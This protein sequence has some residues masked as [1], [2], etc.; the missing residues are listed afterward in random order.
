[1]YKSP[2][3]RQNRSLFGRKATVVYRGFFEKPPLVEEAIQQE[4]Q[5]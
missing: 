3:T 4:G 2:T 1:M 5:E